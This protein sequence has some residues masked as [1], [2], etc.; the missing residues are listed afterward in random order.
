MDQDILNQLGDLLGRRPPQAY[1]DL[2]ADYPQQLRHACRAIDDTDAEGVVADAELLIS[3]ECILALNNE[4][5]CD[6]LL[7]P[8]GVE[9]Q[10]PDSFLVIGETGSGDYYCIDVEAASTEVIQ[11]NHQAV[12]WEIVADSLSEFVEILTETFCGEDGS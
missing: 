11:Y 1:L 12:E 8:E 7:D 5:R 4:A 9:Y 2:L 10:W 3:P 6:G